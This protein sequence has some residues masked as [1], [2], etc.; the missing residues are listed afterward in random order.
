MVMLA[1]YEH[2]FSILFDFIN[3]RQF[4]QNAVVSIL[5]EYEQFPITF[6]LNIK[7]KGL[8]KKYHSNIS[9]LK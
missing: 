6:V 5:G 7:K 3:L 9:I 2:Y 8:V 1:K 4:T